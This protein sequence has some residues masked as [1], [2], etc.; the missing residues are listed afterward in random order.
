MNKT[1]NNTR[2]FFPFYVFLR[3]WSEKK[4]QKRNNKSFFGRHWTTH[5][6]D[7]HPFLFVRE[8][9]VKHSFFSPFRFLVCFPLRERERE[10]L[11]DDDERG[12]EEM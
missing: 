12:K 4:H 2:V 7:H 1:L 6:T 11:C 10:R 8:K 3:L 9:K 5:Y